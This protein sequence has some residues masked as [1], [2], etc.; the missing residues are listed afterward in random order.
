M[1]L[2]K[3]AK[4]ACAG[5][6]VTRALCLLVTIKLLDG[7][8]LDRVKC[9]FC[10]VETSWWVKHTMGLKLVELFPLRL[11]PIFTVTALV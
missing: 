4:L 11:L 2:V 5:R 7:L 9:S 8:G 6:S 10:S 1:T 3:D